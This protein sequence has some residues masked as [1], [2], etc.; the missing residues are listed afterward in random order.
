MAQ[1]A[2]EVQQ[3]QQA[4]EGGAVSEETVTRLRANAAQAGIALS[5]DD[6]ARIREGAYLRNIEA[7]A[8]LVARIPADTIPDDLKDWSLAARVAEEGVP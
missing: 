5:E 7:F 2:P 3:A 6:L 8:R 1:M 4:R